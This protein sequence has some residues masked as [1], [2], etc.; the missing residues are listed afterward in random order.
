M[1]S[2]DPF[3]QNSTT[4]NLLSSLRKPGLDLPPEPLIETSPLSWQMTPWDELDSWPGLLPGSLTGRWLA[5]DLDDTLLMGSFTAGHAWNFYNPIMGAFKKELLSMDWLATT[6]NVF[7]GK[8]ARVPCHR[9]HP[10]LSHPAVT[11][12]FRPGMVEGLVALKKAGLGLILV[13]ASSMRRVEYLLQRFPI[14]R[15]LFGSPR[16]KIVAA[17]GLVPALIEA[18]DHPSRIDHGPSALAHSL[19]PRSLAIKT[20]WAV[21]RGTS[22]P[23]YDLLV[24]DSPITSDVFQSAG[25]Q[26]WLLTVAGGYPCSGYGLFIIHSALARLLGKQSPWDPPLVEYFDAHWSIPKSLEVPPQLEDP[27]YYP[28]LHYRDQF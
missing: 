25:L 5:V 18:S 12:A 26:N 14:L 27:F 28:L 23:Y 10:F 20:P 2:E 1:K 4:K 21:S 8:P 15:E 24:D 6:K 13:T 11:V 16:G 7:R 19:R 3:T 9:A 22:L 17:E